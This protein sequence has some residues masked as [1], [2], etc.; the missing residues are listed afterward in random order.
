MSGG[1]L[2]DTSLVA[3]Y[4]MDDQTY[5][6]RDD[7][8]RKFKER[9]FE[10][11]PDLIPQKEPAPDYMADLAAAIQVGAR[12][13]VDPGERRGQVRF[14]GSVEGLAA[15]A[16]V[17]VAFDEPMGKHDG[18]VAGVRYFDCPAGFGAFL[19]PDKVQVGDF[20]ERDPFAEDD[21]DEI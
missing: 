9:L 12:C 10:M 19:R 1:W 8:A 7:T 14:V 15:G 6:K 11:R 5:D 21:P 17:G 18:S 4:E 3:K 16:W 20:P 2:E 13:Q